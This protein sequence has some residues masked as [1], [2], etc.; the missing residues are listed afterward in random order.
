MQRP[1]R[2]FKRVL[3]T[4]SRSEPLIQVA[5]LVAGALLRRDEKRDVGAFEV[6]NER[7]RKISLSVPSAK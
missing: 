1:L 7:V 5:D 4:R 3:T 2:H 6:P